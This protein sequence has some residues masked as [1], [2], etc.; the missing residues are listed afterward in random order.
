[1]IALLL[2]SVIAFGGQGPVHSGRC[3][4]EQLPRLLP[5]HPVITCTKAGWHITGTSHGGGTF[6]G[7]R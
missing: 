2:T 1:M 3:R 4:G 6:G 5:A 7:I